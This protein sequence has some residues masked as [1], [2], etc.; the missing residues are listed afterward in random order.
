MRCL[1]CDKEL[2]DYEATR[3]SKVT[4]EYYDLCN[5]CFSHVKGNVESE[6]RLDLYG[7]QDEVDLGG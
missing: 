1:A 6:E 7:M 5:G 3:K 4:G 2:Q